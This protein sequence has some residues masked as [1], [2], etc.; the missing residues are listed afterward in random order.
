M[1]DTGQLQLSG[2]ALLWFRQGLTAAA[3]ESY[4]RAIAYFDRVIEVRPDYYE[5]WYERGLA[6]EKRGL[7]RDAIASFDRALSLRPSMDAAIQISYDRGN[8]LQYGLGDY[9]EALN[10]YDQ[11]LQMNAS[12]ELTWQNRGNALLYGLNRPTEAITSFDR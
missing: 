2:D 5:A 1:L 12:H 6:L 11:V 9:S 7:Y 8:A 4:E 3:T 10:A